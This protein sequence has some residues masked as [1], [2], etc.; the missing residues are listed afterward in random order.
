MKSEKTYRLLSIVLLSVVLALSSCNG[1]TGNYGESDE[2]V[3]ITS[4]SDQL[5]HQFKSLSDDGWLQSD[6]LVFDLP[7]FDTSVDLDV[8]ISVRFTNHYPHRNLEF[9]AYLIEQD[10]ANII[11]SLPLHQNDAVIDSLIHIQDSILEKRYQDEQDRKARS[12]L[13]DSLMRVNPDS[14]LRLERADSL[15]KDSMIR[16]YRNS[17]EH[18][19]SLYVAEEVDAPLSDSL[20]SQQNQDSL[21]LQALT[22]SIREKT[23]RLRHTI[24][25]DLF[26]AADEKQGKGVMFLESS[27]SCGIIHLKSYTRYKIIIYHHMRDLKLEG[28]TDIGISL[29]RNTSQKPL[30]NKTRWY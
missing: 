15:R 7:M 8:T 4:G 10:T 14:L 23:Q 29:R 22:D 13:R 25:F 5:Y 1:C 9:Y 6:T 26:S 20:P 12:A 3:A 17:I 28:I 16:A 19:D 27:T 30:F 21:R 2:I 24:D 11:S 18:P